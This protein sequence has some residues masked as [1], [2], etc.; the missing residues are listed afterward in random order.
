M[1]L[2]PAKSTRTRRTLYWL[3][4]N[5]IYGLG[6][7][8]TWTIAGLPWPTYYQS[9]IILFGLAIFNDIGQWITRQGA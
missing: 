5:G 9:F 2:T 6:C 8:L 4:G 7:W 3:L 1:Q